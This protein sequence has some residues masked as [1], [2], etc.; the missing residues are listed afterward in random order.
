MT[1][2]FLDESRGRLHGDDRVATL[3]PKATAVLGLLIRRRGDV[4]SREE[5]VAH[6]WNGIHV[7]PDIVREYIFDI[8]TALADDAKAP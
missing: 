2:W 4:L 8:R 5:I 1:K 7:Q 6:V 3:T